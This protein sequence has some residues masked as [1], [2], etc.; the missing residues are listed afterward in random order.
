MT[1]KTYT[2]PNEN[3]RYTI[4]YA[5]L[6]SEGDRGE[7]PMRLVVIGYKREYPEFAVRWQDKSG[8]TFGG[9]TYQEKETAHNA[10]LRKYL[11]HN[12][13]Y[14]KDNISHLP[15]LNNWV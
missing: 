7:K 12:D 1:K 9:Y 8:A 11:E 10:F 2:N 6:W 15:G 13:S 14:K 3:G 5:T 4:E